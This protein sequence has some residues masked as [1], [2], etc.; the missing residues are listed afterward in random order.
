MTHIPGLPLRGS[1]RKGANESTCCQEGVPLR[2]YCGTSEVNWLSSFGTPLF[3]SRSRLAGRRQ[4]PRASAP[5]ALDSG[6]FTELSLHGRWTVPPKQYALEARRFRQEVG[7]FDWAAIQDWMC[8]P[9]VLAKTGLS[10]KR[11]QRRTIQSFLTLKSLVP[12]FKWVPVLQGWDPADYLRHRDS[13]AAAGIDLTKEATVG[14]GSVCRRQNT[15]AV[16]QLIH[17]LHADGLGNLHGFGF[18]VLGLRRV[19]HLLKSADSMAWSVAYRWAKPGISRFDFARCWSER[20][21]SAGG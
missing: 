18:K 5:W 8:E 12:W 7:N 13:Y 15:L 16:E 19:G 20:I 21:P 2:F 11:H 9:H 4:F 6:G 14:L 10:V 1:A 17:R 3:I